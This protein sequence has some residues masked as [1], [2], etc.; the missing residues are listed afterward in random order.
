M[1]V[2]ETQQVS[3][4][5]SS[6]IKFDASPIDITVKKFVYKL[7]S[8]LSNSS[9]SGKVSVASIWQKYFTMADAQQTNAATRRAYLNSKEELRR[10]LDHME[11]D[12]LIV[13]DGDAVVLTGL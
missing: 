13:I 2:D 9:G 3:D 1:K 11:A 12:E 5:F 4:L 10:A 8:D 7:I 6:S